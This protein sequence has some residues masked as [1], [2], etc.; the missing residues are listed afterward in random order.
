[1]TNTIQPQ[2]D[3]PLQVEGDVEVL[4][5][6]G[7]SIRKSEKIWLC[8]CGHSADKPFCD[9]AHNR[10]EFADA[11]RV[12]ATYINKHPEPGTPAASLRLTLRTDGPINCFGEVEILGADGSA[13]AG[14]QA[15][16]C[17]CGKS[18]NKPFCDGSHRAA[19]R[20]EKS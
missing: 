19:K 18:G 2:I 17:R 1:M 20:L 3:G 9:G 16:L 7:S 12:S 15:N 13:W 4:A 6:D 5:A 10:A 8:R 14:S 11:A